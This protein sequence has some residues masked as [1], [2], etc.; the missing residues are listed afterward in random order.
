M[1]MLAVPVFA[2]SALILTWSSS[3]ASGEREASWQLGRADLWID[4][5][6]VDQAVAELPV[7][8]ATLPYTTGKTIIAIDDRH[9]SAEYWAADV[10]A[11]MNAGKYVLRSG[12]IPTTQ[13]EVA[14]TGSLAR[15]LNRGIGDT[16]RAGLPQ[17]TLAVVGIIDT[18]DQLGRKALIVAGAHPLSSDASMRIMVSLP[19]VA[20]SWRPDSISDI[21]YLDRTSLMPSPA[22]QA[23][24]TAGLTVVV[25]FAGLQIMLLAGAAFAVGARRQ[26][27]ELAM[28]AAV[29]AN[30]RQV[31]RIVLAYGV[32]L[33]AIAGLFGVA[34]GIVVFRFSRSGI[35]RLV[36]H[37]L[38]DGPPPVL[39]LLFVAIVAVAVGL[40]ATA[41]PARSVSRQSIKQTLI[42]R[43]ADSVRSGR[44]LFRIGAAVALIG[45]FAAAYAASPQVGDARLA[46]GGAVLVLLGLAALAPFAVEM[47]ERFARPAPLTLRLALRHASRYQ[48]RTAAAVAAV[49]AAVAGSVGISLFLSADTRTGAAS[50]PN[51]RPGQ[52]L[53]S[54][55]SVRVLNPEGLTELA[56]TL[57]VTGLVPVQTANAAALFFFTGADSAEPPPE[58]SPTVVVGG[59]E[60]VKIVTGEPAAPAIIDALDRGEAVTFYP[61]L[62]Q[63]G[64]TILTT[65][66]DRKITLPARLVPADDY[67]RDLPA[68]VVSAATAEQNGLEVSQSGLVLDTSRV[69]TTAE[70]D[71]SQ[72]VLLRSQVAAGEGGPTTPLQLTLGHQPTE[73]VQTDPMVYVLAAISGVVT[74]VAG[75]VAVGLATAEMRDDLSTLAAIGAP[76]RLPRWLAASQAGLIVGVGTI[77]GLTAGTAPAAGLI[78]L[79]DDLTWHLPWWLPPVVALGMPAIAVLA[80]AVISRPNLQLTRRLT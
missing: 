29:G 62:M 50:Q 33:G 70:L 55:E 37:P 31:S 38:A 49:C 40:G 77:L 39:S 79:R 52:V 67:Y 30:R 60:L 45:A 56:D 61:Q 9:L 80:T 2:G 42:G 76:T 69:P 59:P 14:L 25:G 26:R 35:E 78:A 51:A 64:A 36:N 24:R 43:E 5:G 58:L 32:M 8:S 44:R 3:Y 10:S 19:P 73:H 63:G 17:R 54:A 12:T 71:A 7:G 6:N 1:L 13:A 66:D 68:I 34:L 11:D 16:I 75:S 28:I 20:A 21:G 18:A 65:T 47:L 46:A 4:G 15:Q 27:R 41:G 57:P 22:E 72:S 48:F 53:L 23:I 74:L